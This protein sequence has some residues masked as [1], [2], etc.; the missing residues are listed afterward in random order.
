MQIWLLS[1]HV[2][3]ELC[4]DMQRRETIFYQV[5]HDEK[6]LIAQMLNVVFI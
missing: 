1:S 4:Y 2:R 6:I 5:A 3:Q